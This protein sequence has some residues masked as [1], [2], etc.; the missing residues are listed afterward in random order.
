MKKI[1]VSKH[2][3]VPKHDKVSDKEKEEILKKY[4]ISLDMLPRISKKDAVIKDL[5]VKP[6]DIIKITRKSHTS[7]ETIFY[8]CVVNA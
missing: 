5:G 4:N 6:G 8:R 3:L 7:G 1:D 2:V